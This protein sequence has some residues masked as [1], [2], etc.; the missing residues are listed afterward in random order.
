[1][2][3][4][5][6]AQTRLRLQRRDFIFRAIRSF[7]YQDGFAEVDPPILVPGTGCEP[8]IDPLKVEVGLGE[9]RAAVQRYLHTSP[10][11][12]LKRLLARVPEPCFFLGHVFRNGERTA[13]HL[14]EFAMLEW[15]RPHHTLGDLVEDCERLLH[16]I[17]QTCAQKGL[18]PCTHAQQ[19]L[20][21]SPFDVMSM[22]DLW[23]RHAKIDLEEALVLVDEKGDEEMVRI[24]KDAGFYLRPQ[25]DFDDAFFQVMLTAVE[26]NIGLECPTVI[27]D[28]PKQMA[29]LSRIDDDNPL[30]AKRFELYAGGFELANAFDELADGEE[31]KRRFKADNAK[32]AALGTSPLVLDEAFLED[33]DQMPP[34]V[35][36][37]FGIDRL[38]Q[39]VF[40]ASDIIDT[41][42][43]STQEYD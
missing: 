30:F 21:N 35:G 38:L 1:M 6:H 31:Q 3:N 4:Q 29:I 43:L 34:T 40:G 24:V 39:L 16:H 41:Y 42:P 18:K 13:K 25:A 10:E 32:R 20:Q 8:H 23:H 17:L 7:F 37:A 36:I 9:G 15:Y 14:P 11:L 12:Y 5:N 22:Q 26:P 33:L 28:W 19:L 2:K 27:T